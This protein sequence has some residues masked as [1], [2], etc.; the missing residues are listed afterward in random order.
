MIIEGEEE[1]LKEEE[2]TLIAIVEAGI[3]ITMVE[4]EARRSDHSEDEMTEDTEAWIVV[5]SE[6]EVSKMLLFGK[7]CKN[8]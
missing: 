1:I 3:G 6:E 4:I 5:V 7:L 8:H 2:G